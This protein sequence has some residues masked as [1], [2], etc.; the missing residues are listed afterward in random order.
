MYVHGNRCSGNKSAATILANILGC[1]PLWLMDLSPNMEILPN[2]VTV[3]HLVESIGDINAIANKL[4]KPS[5]ERLLAYAQGMYD[6]QNQD[7]KGRIA[8]VE[9]KS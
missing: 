8:Y 7:K 4:D 2:T 1:N 3:V 6:I 5:Q 9:T